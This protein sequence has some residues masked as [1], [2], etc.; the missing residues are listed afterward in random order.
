MKKKSTLIISVI[1]IIIILIGV[2]SLLYPSKDLENS[3]GT[4]V[5]SIDGLTNVEGT[6]VQD[7]YPP[8]L[9]SVEVGG[10][11]F[12]A[13]NRLS[14]AIIYRGDKVTIM[15]VIYYPKDTSEFIVE[16]LF[17]RKSN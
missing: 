16:R 12:P 15:K 8:Q 1:G 9:G 17:V 11:I 13:E 7:I 14:S 4:I 6:C 10:K 2:L 5:S 3:K